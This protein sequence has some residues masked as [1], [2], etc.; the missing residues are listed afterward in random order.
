MSVSIILLPLAISAVAAYHASTSSPMDSTAI[1]VSTRMR[2]VGLLSEALESTGAIVE[3]SS[4]ALSA[5]WQGVRATFARDDAGIWSA[6]LT[7]DVDHDRAV[8]IVQA[9]DQAYGHQVQQA[10][11]SRIEA[12]AG[13]AGMTVDSS[14]RNEDDSVTVI[15]NVN[16]ASA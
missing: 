7:G 3:R 8:S 13:S 5:D 2:D 14:R 15:L 9:V 16:R 6:Q 10:V 11:L 12:R 1:N 4:D